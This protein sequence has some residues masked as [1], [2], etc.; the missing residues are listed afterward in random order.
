VI[1]GFRVSPGGAQALFGVVPDLTALAKVLSGGLPGG[2]VAA[3][4]DIL[5]IIE[6]GGGGRRMNH[7]GTFNGNPLSAAA[8][9]AALTRVADGTPSAQAN[10]MGASLRQKLNS[11]FAGRNLPMCA[12]GDYSFVHLIFDYRGPRP[13]SDDFIPYDGSLEQLD[14]PQEP[15][16]LKAFRAAMILNG[17]DLP[18]RGMFL[19]CE[20]T[21]SDVDATVAAVSASVAMM[22]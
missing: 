11:M 12:Y 4:A 9:V 3:P 13:T 21:E 18:G 2:A 14:P 10:R 6:G 20:H 1:T 16:D 15:V 7:P 5:G 8:G 22:A 17:V 19:T